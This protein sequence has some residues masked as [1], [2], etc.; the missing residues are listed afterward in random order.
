MKLLGFGADPF[1]AKTENYVKEHAG[2]VFDGHASLMQH[3]LLAGLGAH[4]QGGDAQKAYWAKCRTSFVLARAPD[5]S[6]Q[7]R[8]WK[9]TIGSHRNNDVEVGEA[10]TTACW[11]I[12]VGCRPAADAPPTLPLLLAQPT[13]V[14][15]PK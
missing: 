12:V 2:D 1:C 5:G 13:E 6:L 3:F 7:P 9:E 4:A 15:K 14:A 10:W 8:P 11:A